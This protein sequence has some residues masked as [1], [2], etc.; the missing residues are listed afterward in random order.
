M[1]PW[2]DT[3]SGAQFCY[4]QID[5][6]VIGLI[7]VAHALSNLCRF[8]GHSI[9][10]YSV[11]EHSVLASYLVP[12]SLAAE[13]LMHD[14][15]EA[16][17]GDMNSPLGSLLP[18]FKAIRHQVDRAV[19]DRFRLRAAMPDE[20]KYADMQMLAAEQQQAMRS[21]R[22]WMQIENIEVPDVTL[23]FWSPMQARGKFL[24][25]AYELGIRH[26]DV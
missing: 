21:R 23:R 17:V 19:R 5:P 9:E 4:L 15:H 24:E 2:I 8:T 13:A 1:S 26:H 22:P 14:A 3:H 7:D 25:R 12:P 10:F 20:V 11:A 6:N 16:F 18:E